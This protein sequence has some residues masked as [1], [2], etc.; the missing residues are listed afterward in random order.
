MGTGQ[1]AVVGARPDTRGSDRIRRTFPP[2]RIAFPKVDAGG[3]ILFR[4]RNGVGIGR[5]DR[6][7]AG[8]SVRG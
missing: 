1:T 6:R 5:Y 4:D 8:H 2:I 7:L 3:D